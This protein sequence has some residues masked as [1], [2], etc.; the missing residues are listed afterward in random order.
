[1]SVPP[2][3][4]VSPTH[5]HGIESDEYNDVSNWI[6]QG[7]A[8]SLVPVAPLPKKRRV[9][10][11][12]KK[13][14]VKVK[15]RIQH[16]KE[17]QLAAKNRQLLPEIGDGGTENNDAISL[18]PTSLLGEKR[19]LN[20]L[21]RIVKKRRKHLREEAKQRKSESAQDVM[22]GQNEDHDVE[23]SDWRWDV[24]SETWMYEPLQEKTKLKRKKN[25]TNKSLK[26]R[27]LAMRRTWNTPKKDEMI[28]KISINRSDLHTVR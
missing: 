12:K 1:L 6:E 11:G 22:E 14:S 17:K 19:K 18:A 2:P 26:N 23:Q 24:V 16:R 3:P 8:I 28:A 9:A 20:R 10:V 5:F 4:N 15:Q 25:L 21:I 7:T 27:I 13:M